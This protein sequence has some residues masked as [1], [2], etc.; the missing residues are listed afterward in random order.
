MTLKTLSELRSR[1]WFSDTGMRGFAH[2]QRMQ[3]QGIRRE[4]VMERPVVAVLNTWSDLSPCH[5]HLRERAEAVKRGILLAGA[6]PVEL[7]AMSLGEVMVK[8]TSMLYRNFL[9]M[10]VEELLRSHPIDGAV[11]LGGCDKTT[12]GTVMGAISMGV[13]AIFC[14][15]GPMLNDRQV[16]GGVTRQIGAGTH[17]RMFWDELQAGRIGTDDWVA[18]EAKM[19]RSPGT[20]NTMGTASKIGRAHV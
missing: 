9:A 4:D 8:P 13:P 14:P 1:R 12:P 11:L 3:Q 2:R 20:C 18:L 7:P 15:A 17:T 10:E 5:S 19:T 6:L 16:Q